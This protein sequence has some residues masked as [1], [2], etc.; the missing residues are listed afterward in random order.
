[1]PYQGTYVAG[2]RHLSSVMRGERSIAPAK[3]FR[4]NSLPRGLFEHPWRF[5]AR[6]R[7]ARVA[8]IKPSLEVAD[9]A[10]LFGTLVKAGVEWAKFR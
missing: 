7:S 8:A 3:F 10:S 4:C 9:K 1:V 2:L 5:R 6:S